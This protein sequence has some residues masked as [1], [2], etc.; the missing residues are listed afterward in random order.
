[1]TNAGFCL[2]RDAENL[3]GSLSWEARRGLIDLLAL[4]KPE[5]MAEDG[6]R[7]LLAGDLLQQAIAISTL[8]CLAHAD[9]DRAL[10]FATNIESLAWTP[11][12]AIR[13]AAQKALAAIDRALPMS[14]ERPLAAFYRLEV[15]PTKQ[16]S[17]PLHAGFP[18]PGEPL[19]DTE[20]P[21][22]LTHLHHGALR[23]IADATGFSFEL[24]ARR[25]AQFMPQVA[26]VASWSAAAER[27]LLDRYKNI[28]LK[29]GYRR[30]RALVAQQAFGLLLAELCDGGALV[31]LDRH[32]EEHLLLAD[33]V[34][35]LFDPVGRPE[36]LPVP[37]GA[38]LG[39][40]PTDGWLAAVEDALPPVSI[41][42][43]GQVVL[44]ELTTVVSQDHDRVEECRLSVVA[45]SQYPLDDKEMPELHHFLHRGR[46]SATDYPNLDRFRPPS[47]SAVIAG[48][49]IFA[50]SRFLALNP[51]IGRTLGWISSPDRPFCWFD[52]A[53]NLMVETVLWTQGNVEL[54]DTGG[55]DQSASEGWLVLA[56]AAAW[57]KMRPLFRY[58]V[59][60]RMAGRVSGFARDGSRRLRVALDRQPL[61]F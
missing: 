59:Q 49:S 25:M 46:Y 45:H 44:G 23:K 22:D 11:A 6:L 57:Q 19:P 16:A 37:S 42:P 4:T 32:Y 55:L 41:T 1:M 26:P 52:A 51:V 5:E 10:A 8:Q 30:P 9:P 43:N 48:G 3:G 61:T 36:W 60:H 47:I 35:N 53:G 12:G 31:W 17:Q 58:F 29:L 13:L 56:S 20:D 39:A 33:P 50:A 54:H 38:E 27:A 24:L 15:A 34:A 28:G 21:F 14:P 18:A 40:H 2:A 7:R